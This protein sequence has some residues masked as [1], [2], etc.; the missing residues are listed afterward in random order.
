ADGVQVLMDVPATHLAPALGLVAEA[1]RAPE[2]SD[3][4][5]AR[6]QQLRLGAIAQVEANS[7]ALANREY[8]RRILAADVRA[9]RP[10]GGDRSQVRSITPDLVRDWAASLLT[11]DRITLVVGGDLD[12]QVLDLLEASFGDWTGP[13]T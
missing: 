12:P 11:P 9:G 5:V 3:A 8:R 10:T 1:V 4:D 6:H 7:S 2:L 13:A